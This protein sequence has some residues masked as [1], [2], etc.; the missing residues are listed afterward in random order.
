[1]QE[2]EFLI[3]QDLFIIE[4]G[5][6]ADVLLPATPFDELPNPDAKL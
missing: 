3:S 5:T 4:S 2:L 6:F 1:M